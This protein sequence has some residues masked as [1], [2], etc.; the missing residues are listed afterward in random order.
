VEIFLSRRMMYRSKGRP[1]RIKH[2][3]GASESAPVGHSATRE[4][5][6]PSFWFVDVSFPE[7][8]RRRRRLQS[9]T[10]AREGVCVACGDLGWLAFLSFKLLEIHRGEF[11]LPTSA[12][13]SSIVWNEDRI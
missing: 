3:V 13:V 4:F 2:F 7:P 5:K 1:F 9:T 10:R 8:G 11:N 12:E 6:D